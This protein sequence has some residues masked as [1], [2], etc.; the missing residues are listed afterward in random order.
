MKMADLGEINNVSGVFGRVE[1]KNMGK[2][3]L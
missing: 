2:G 3:I 1:L